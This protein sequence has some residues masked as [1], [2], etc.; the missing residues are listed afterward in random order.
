MLLVG[1]VD[2]L[3]GDVQGLRQPPRPDLGRDDPRL[4]GHPDAVPVGAP[5][6]RR[7]LGRPVLA[8]P[9]GPRARRRAARRDLGHPDQPDARRAP[10]RGRW[11]RSP[12]AATSSPAT[13]RCTRSC[14]SSRRSTSCSRRARSP[15]TAA[16]APS[17]CASSSCRAPRCP[18]GSGRPRSSTA[19]RPSSPGSWR[20]ARPARASSSPRSRSSPRGRRATS[21][22]RSAS[23]PTTRASS[24][25]RRSPSTAPV[26]GRKAVERF[27]RDHLAGATAIDVTRKQVAGERVTWSARWHPRDAP[28]PVRG[29]I[30]VAFDGDRVASLRLIAP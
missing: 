30:E 27:L 23:S 22:R 1:A 21:T 6:R 29:A 10:S 2:V 24:R 12:T 16:T 28:A 17:S 20:T 13:C 15:A 7:L 19:T 25:G 26:R 8:E 4:G 14:T 3:T 9:A 18:A 11:S 5:R